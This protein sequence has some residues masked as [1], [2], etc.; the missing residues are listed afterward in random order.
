ME[1]SYSAAGAS[2][3]EAIGKNSPL[4]RFVPGE[5]DTV[6]PRP[7]GEW[8]AAAKSLNK[9]LPERV[10]LPTAKLAH[11]QGQV[12]AQPSEI[13]LIVRAARGFGQ[14]VFVATDLDA[15]PMRAWSDRP[16]L[17]AAVLGLPANEPP[18]EA[19][20]AAESYGYDDLAGQLRSALE[21]FRG[22][23]LAAVLRRRHA[24]S[25][26]HSYDRSR[27]LLSAPPHAPRDDL[28]L[29]DVSDRCRPF[30][31]RRLLGFVLAEARRAAGQPGGPD[32]CR[33]RWNRPRRKLV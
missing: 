10:K 20:A 16:L 3:A 2:A 6:L 27:R 29:V 1:R 19:A 18:P 25:D 30:C 7:A 26:I 8:E 13:P 4:A 17:L 28:D 12:E 15:P 9:I 31:R 14:V 11:P 21:Q 22:V 24:R 33:G 5:I 32:R 23:P